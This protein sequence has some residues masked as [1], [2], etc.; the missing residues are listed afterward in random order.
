MAD[1]PLH[2]PLTLTEYLYVVISIV[3]LGVLCVLLL[4]RFSSITSRLGVYHVDEPMK[5]RLMKLYYTYF[6]LM[7]LITCFV[8]VTTFTIL[9]LFEPSISDYSGVVHNL[10]LVIVWLAVTSSL[11]LS[12]RIYVTTGLVNIDGV[13]SYMGLDWKDM[14]ERVLSTLYSL[15]VTIIIL[16]CFGLIMT[17]LNVHS[18]V[19]GNIDKM[20]NINFYINMSFVKIIICTISFPFV[21][22]SV[23]EGLRYITSLF[24]PPMFDN[25]GNISHATQK[26][27][28]KSKEPI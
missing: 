19:G 21:L 24:F 7:A 4:K 6:T 9:P 10:N 26:A 2:V 23:G 12:I 5:K 13:E 1:T 27:Q 25:E 11:L 17:I 8:V 20:M 22:A 16:L 15:L 28:D 14:R 18:D 3:L